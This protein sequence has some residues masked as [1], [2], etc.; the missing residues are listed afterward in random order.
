MEKIDFSKDE[1]YYLNYFGDPSHSRFSHYVFPKLYYIVPSVAFAGIAV[2]QDSMA[3]A[4]TAYGLILVYECFNLVQ[5]K[6]WLRVVPSIFAKYEARIDAL[7]KELAESG[8][9]AR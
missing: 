3:F 4:F 8:R 5:T 1:Q 6:R 7:E 2:F 9:K